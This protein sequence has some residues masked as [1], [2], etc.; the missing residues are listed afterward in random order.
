MHPLL[1]KWLNKLGIQ[2]IED[3]NPEEQQKFAEWQKVFTTEEATIDQI[4]VFC[5]SQIGMI[6]QKWAD[7]S[8]DEYRK[9]D[10][11]PYHTCYKALLSIISAPSKEKTR[12]EEHLNKL[13]NLQTLVK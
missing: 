5:S 13:I 8:V 12:L 4:S 6:E 9:A 11:I 2:S 7:F 1:H 10:L 3:L